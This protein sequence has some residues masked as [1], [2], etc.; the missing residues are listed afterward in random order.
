MIAGA[1]DWYAKGLIIPKSVTE[2]TTRYFDEQDV[3]GLWI[4]EECDVDPENR[5][6]MEKTSDLYQS[7]SAWAR[8]HGEQPG[9]QTT[10]NDMLRHRGLNPGEQIKAFNTRGCRGIRL[11]LA[12]RE[13]DR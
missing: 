5:Y 7:W 8:Q 10:F 3:F 12:Q 13:D 11:K 2:A 6:L 4:A 1:V 9:T